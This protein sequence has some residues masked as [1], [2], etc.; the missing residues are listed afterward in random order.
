M[1]FGIG[2]QVGLSPGDF[3]LDG[4]PASPPLKGHNPPFLCNVHCGQTTGWMK[5]PLGTEADLAPGHIDGVPAL[6]ER[7]T[8]APIF[9]AHVYCGHGRPSQLL[10]ISCI[11]AYIQEYP[12]LRVKFHCRRYRR[13]QSGLVL[14][15][16]VRSTLCDVGVT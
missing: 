1:P 13:L 5:M 10:L 15:L 12:G 9:S 14:G 16:A 11:I 2:M 8:A 6:H 7:G 3:V 4:D